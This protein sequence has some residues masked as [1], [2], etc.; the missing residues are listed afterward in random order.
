MKLKFRLIAIALVAIFPFCGV[1]A[2]A[3]EKCPIKRAIEQ[4]TLKEK[5][6]QMFFIRPETLVCPSDALSLE[7]TQL[8]E[9]MSDF[10]REYPVG[11]FCLFTKNIITPDQLVRFTSDLHALS[12]K[13]L[14][15]IDEEGGRVARLA[16]NDAF[17]LERF[18]SM[19]A[20]AAGN[21]RKSVG[22]AARY[23]GSYVRKYGFDIDFAPV[24]DV[25][26]NPGNIVIG[27]RA[28]SDDPEVAAKMVATYLRALQSCGV[29]GCLKHFPGHGDT[30][31]DT[32]TGYA[33]SQKTWDEMAGCEM[34]P[35]KAGI[36]AGAEII[37]TAHI[38]APNVT[39]TD[40][41]STLSPV[42]LQEKLRGQLGYKGIITTD[43]MEMGAISQHYDSAQA[44]VEAVKAGAD[45][46]LMPKDFIQAV[47]GIVS[48]VEKGEIDEKRIDESL[49]R[50]L[51]LKRRKG[52]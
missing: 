6:C 51:R 41:P 35:F 36:A 9:E 50:I 23:I 48:A 40:K 10:F 38:A 31:N 49:C 3:A 15:C 45:I 37:M 52:F 11:G 28:F 46:I 24:A 4:M 1:S 34:I 29:T 44:A 12:P 8:S 43:A 47:N 2:K 13:P 27:P 39:G 25:N 30:L 14:L 7:V 18:K 42:I 26:T 19:T 32:H 21:D 17:G 33:S 20:L 22:D 16:N 5:V